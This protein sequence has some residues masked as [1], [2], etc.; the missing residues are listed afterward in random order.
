M[1]RRLTNEAIKVY[2]SFNKKEVHTYNR[3]S[4]FSFYLGSYT[5]NHKTEWLGIILLCIL[6]AQLSPYNTDYLIFQ[7]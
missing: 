1:E 3:E 7:F 6:R 2:Y 5:R 4:P